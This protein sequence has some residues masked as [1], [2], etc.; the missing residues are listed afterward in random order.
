MKADQGAVADQAHPLA[1][2][3]LTS[4]LH[5]IST[6]RS[7]RLPMKSQRILVAGGAGFLGSHLC[8]RLLQQGHRLVCVDNLSTGSRANIAPLIENPRFEFLEHDI[9]QPLFLI[10]FVF[11]ER[12]FKEFH[13]RIA[14]KSKNVGS[15]AIEE[16]TVV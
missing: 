6:G 15:H 9:T 2:Y 12:P 14:L 3:L 5:S 13:L 7:R 1:Q 11:R 16:P 8:E 4:G 10:L